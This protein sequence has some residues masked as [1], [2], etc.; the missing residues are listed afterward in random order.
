MSVAAAN[1]AAAAGTPP[2]ATTAASNL[3]VAEHTEQAI[4]LGDRL[5]ELV[6]DPDAFLAALKESLAE[7][8]DPAY[9]AGIRSVTPGLGPVLGVRLPLLSAAHKKF[10]RGTRKT[11]SVLVLD[12]TDRLLRAELADVRW[13]GMWNLERLLPADPER[14]W[15][16]MRR[17]AADSG[18][19]ISV[20]TLAHAYGAG[21]LREPRRWSELD[22]LVYS[23]SRWERRLVGSTIAT[24]PFAKGAPGARAPQ[25]AARGL[26]LIGLLIG[27]AEPDVQK[28][29]SWALRSL[30]LVDAP[31][32]AAF[33]EAE[34]QTA[35]AT[36]D[37]HRAWVVRDSLSKLPAEAAARLRGQL[38]GIRRRPGAPATSRAAVAAAEFAAA[39]ISG[40]APRA[41]NALEE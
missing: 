34:T 28:A 39:G 13:F 20:D 32:V 19:W 8:A 9:A 37:G 31:A 35:R 22:Q 12:V 6:A 11:S 4:A 17:A 26:T 23:P 7:I 16:L 10:V 24:L 5:A 18:E 41:T 15:Q 14:S 27:D 36:D 25:V 3:F 33:A 2:S 21:I 1:A 38:D 40:S 30:T 29:L